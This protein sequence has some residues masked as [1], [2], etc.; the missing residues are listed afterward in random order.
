MVLAEIP[1]DAPPI[2]RTYIMEGE[3]FAVESPDLSPDF[4]KLMEFKQAEPVLKND[5]VVATAL[6]YEAKQ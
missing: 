1:Q 3:E 4:A 5:I 2:V 6:V